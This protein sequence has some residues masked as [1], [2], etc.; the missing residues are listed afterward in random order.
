MPAH[1]RI[2]IVILV[3]LALAGGACGTPTGPS[4]TLAQITLASTTVVAGTTSEGIVTLS[5]PAP[6]G[7][8]DV[9]L[10]SSDGAVTLPAS[11]TVNA[12]SISG[13]FTARTRV[14]AADTTATITAAV[15]G[16]KREIALRVI[17]PVPRPPALDALQV[18][19]SVVK[20]GQSARGT[21]VLTAAAPTGGF[22]VNLRSSNGVATVPSTVTVPSGAVS[23]TFTVIS[24]PVELDTQL[25]ITASS[26]DVTR[27]VPFHIAR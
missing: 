26:G 14:I 3:M 21:V 16:Q 8:V 11:I 9:T 13:T 18:E 24:G 12:G 23:A 27:T 7:G 25:E 15:A 20:G 5:G 6:G 1:E 17:A 22:I 19:P 4:A 10:S 2:G